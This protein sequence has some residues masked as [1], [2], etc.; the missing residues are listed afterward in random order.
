M[1]SV[2]ARVESINCP[3]AVHSQIKLALATKAISV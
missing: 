2:L 3:V 1:S